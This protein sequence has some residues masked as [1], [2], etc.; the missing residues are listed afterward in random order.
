MSEQELG[1]LRER[2]AVAQSVLEHKAEFFKTIESAH[3]RSVVNVLTYHQVK[4]DF[5]V[6]RAQ[7]FEVRTAIAQTE[8]K[9]FETEQEKNQVIVDNDIRRENEIKE[10]SA[11]LADDAV[12]QKSIGAILH[13]F[14][15]IATRTSSN[16]R[17]QSSIT[18]LRQGA[19]GREEIKGDLLF[20]LQPGDILQIGYGAV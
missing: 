19:S 12:A 16:A 11:A 5:E 14:G 2:L 15:E 3:T 18:I 17:T 4:S 20:P 9:L 1:I 6:A 10:L 7:L 13:D 8:R